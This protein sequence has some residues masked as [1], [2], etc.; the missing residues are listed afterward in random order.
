MGK[1]ERNTMTAAE[2]ENLGALTDVT[3]AMRVFGFSRRYVCELCKSG[4]FK[5]VKIGN[6]WRINTRSML[7]YA[8]L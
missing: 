4:A 8:G 3:T 6:V 1:T 7:D 2:L 5:A